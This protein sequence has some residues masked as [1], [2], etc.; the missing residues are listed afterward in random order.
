MNRCK[1]KQMDTKDCAKMLGRILTLEE[2]RVLVKNV[3]GRKIE[4]QKKK[5]HQEGMQK[6][7]EELRWRFHGSETIMERRPKENVGRDRS[8]AE[9]RRRLAP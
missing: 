9:R 8:L 3:R 5:G 2:G 4:G 7:S 6:A 1:P